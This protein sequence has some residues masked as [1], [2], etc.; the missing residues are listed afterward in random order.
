[1]AYRRLPGLKAVLENFVDDGVNGRLVDGARSIAH[2]L[3]DLL[4]DHAR[5]IAMGKAAQAK[6][7]SSGMWE[8][9]F[10]HL[11]KVVLG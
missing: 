6:V 3:T 9:A 8:Q 1:M 7:R 5:L 2:A 10:E 11:M 4:S